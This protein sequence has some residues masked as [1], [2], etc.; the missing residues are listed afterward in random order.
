[1][2]SKKLLSLTII[3]ML[4]SPLCVMSESVNSASMKGSYENAPPPK[5]ETKP[6]PPS[7]DSHA[8]VHGYWNWVNSK[9]V[10]NKGKY[11]AAIKERP[12]IRNPEYRDLP[13]SEHYS[14]IPGNWSETNGDWFWSGGHHVQ[15]PFLNAHWKPGRWEYRGVGWVWI[16]GHW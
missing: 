1:M 13:P 2:L 16:P 12:P 11:A 10:W 3:V 14:W 7:S 9:W 5:L 8:W 4:T 6:V 15:K